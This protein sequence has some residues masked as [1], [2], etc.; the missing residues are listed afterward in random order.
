MAADVVNARIEGNIDNHDVIV[1]DRNVRARVA[2]DTDIE[3][4]RERERVTLR[5]AGR[6]QLQ[7][8]VFLLSPRA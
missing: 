2:S 6:K 1:S 8:N 7:V 4:E 5:S 3:K